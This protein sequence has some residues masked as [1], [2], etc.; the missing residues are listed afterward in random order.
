MKAGYFHGRVSDL[1]GMQAKHKPETEAWATYE[2]AIEVFQDVYR[3]EN[4]KA[5][6]ERQLKI[7]R[8]CRPN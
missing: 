2:R 4:G 6:L 1:E 3:L 8:S 7:R 5:D